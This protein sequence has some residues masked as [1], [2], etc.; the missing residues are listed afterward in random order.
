MLATNPLK[1]NQTL[2]NVTV[3]FKKSFYFGLIYSTVKCTVTADVVEF[4]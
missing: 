2:A 3:N 1:E 4:K